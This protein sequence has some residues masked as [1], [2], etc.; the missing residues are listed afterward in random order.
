MKYSKLLVLSTSLICSSI[1]YCAD[2]KSG[3]KKEPI[4]YPKIN[5]VK[6]QFTDNCKPIAQPTKEEKRSVSGFQDPKVYKKFLAAVD[7]VTNDLLDEGLEQFKALYARTKPKTYERAAVAQNFSNIYMLRED[8]DTAI[9]YQLEA[10]ESQALPIAAETQLLYNMAY[11]ELAEEKWDDALKWGNRWFKSSTK[12]N[13]DAYLL[14]ASAYIGKKQYAKAACSAKFAIELNTK[15]LPKKS[16][17]D[18]LLSSHWE[19]KDIEGTA[20]VNKQMIELF[21]DKVDLWVQLSSLYGRLKRDQDSLAIQDIAYRN[22]MLSKPTHIMSL[23]QM[24]A[25]ENVPYKS[26]KIVEKGIV[27]K[28]VEDNEKNWKFV[29]S[30]FRNARENKLAAAAYAK[31][32]E[33]SDTGEHFI[34]QGQILYE[35]D[36][37]KGAIEALTNG[38]QKGGLSGKKMGAAYISRGAAKFNLK[39]YQDALEDMNVAKKYT[40]SR[41]TADQWINYIKSQMDLDK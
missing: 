18:I 36:E 15:T 29:A 28:H 35:I 16:S 11:I 20:K 14:M 4:V 26:A 17:F 1:A 24:Y 32:A 5:V 2:E 12:I 27:D 25:L 37:N 40:S 38:L 30:K 39:R 21:P 34:T 33:H 3:E 9:K 10:V 7:S 19:L 13:P 6:T 8:Y 41:K 23:A 22:N 31:A